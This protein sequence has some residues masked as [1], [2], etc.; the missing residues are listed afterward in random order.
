MKVIFTKLLCY[1]HY[2][3][4]FSTICTLIIT[5]IEL[6]ATAWQLTISLTVDKTRLNSC[7]YQFPLITQISPHTGL[8][9]KSSTLVR[10]KLL[11]KHRYNTMHLWT[12]HT[13][14]RGASYIAYPQKDI[15]PCIVTSLYITFSV[16]VTD[17][18]QGV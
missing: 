16:A 14:N 7:S 2:I 13:R 6:E 11:R 3:S 1:T 9:R 8:Q 17:T 15:S 5:I 12:V 4:T 10:L 18:G